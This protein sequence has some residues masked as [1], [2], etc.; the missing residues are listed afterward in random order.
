[1]I[2]FVHVS[3]SRPITVTASPRASIVFARSNTGVVGS[4]LTRGIDICVGLFC[5]CVVMY[6]GSGLAT[7]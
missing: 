7:G 1:V 3:R 6:V 5:V 4:N 2:L